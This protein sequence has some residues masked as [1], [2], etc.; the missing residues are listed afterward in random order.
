MKK[1]IYLL[2][3][4]L[5]MNV[6][7]S[8]Q[9]EVEEGYSVD[10]IKKESVKEGL[11][12]RALFSE[13][14]V[15]SVSEASETA[16]K[17]AEMFADESTRADVQEPRIIESVGVYG[18]KNTPLRSA[19]VSE[20][21]LYYV[22]NFEDNRGFAIVSADDRIPTQILAY[23]DNG[24]LENDV[25][26]PGLRYG[27]ELMQHYVESSIDHFENKKDSLLAEAEKKSSVVDAKTAETRA[28]YTGTAYS[29]LSEQT[30]GP[31]ISVTWGQGHPYNMNVGK[32]CDDN[33]KNGGKAPTGC[34]ATSTAQLMSYWKY[35][36]SWDFVAMDWTKM[37]S[38]K[39]ATDLNKSNIAILMKLIGVYIGM[40][41]DCE[42][43]GAY[44]SD[45]YDLLGKLGYKKLFKTEFDMG[46]AIG[47][48]QLN[49]PFW[50]TGFA[51]Y[52]N[53]GHSWLIDGYKRIEFEEVNYRVDTSTGSVQTT[54]SEYSEFYFHNNWG[55]NGEGNGYFASGCFDLQDAYS[56]DEEGKVESTA[57]FRYDNKMYCVYR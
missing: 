57:D 18:R 30:V 46:L 11:N 51:N 8:C 19:N 23:V 3:T 29:V 32:L 6:L 26:N 53:G 24:S 38:S 12:L 14:H 44:T 41:Y 45:A 48:L 34:V 42:G 7:Q 35:P 40:K 43:S 13:N 2:A 37:C 56:Y 5:L 22:F 54:T 16:L 47:T 25:D 33:D 20:D 31:L 15:I 36:Y 27:L 4:L 9:D 10:S 21:T 28:I 17:A 39:T 50:M 49:L 52:N 55:W 1:K